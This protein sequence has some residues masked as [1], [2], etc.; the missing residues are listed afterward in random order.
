MEHQP[1]TEPG[2]GSSDHRNLEDMNIQELVSV[3]RTAFMA[4]DFD[5][6]EEVLVSRYNRIQ[7]EILHL[8]E[9]FELEKL[10]RFQAKEDLRKREELCE[11]YK[12]NYETLLKEVKKKSSLTE[13]DNVGELRKKKNALE[14]EVCELRKLKEK[15]KG[16]SNALA[17][18]RIKVGVLE[19]DKDA[20]F[21]VKNSELKKSMK[22]NSK[23][24]D[25]ENVGD[26]EI[27]ND[28]ME[29]TPL[30][31][32]EPPSKRSKTAQGASSPVISQMKLGASSSRHPPISCMCKSLFA[33][34]HKPL[35]EE[36]FPGGP[37]DMSVL[38][39]FE[40]HIAARI[41]RREEREL[42]RVVTHGNKLKKF[43]PIQLPQPILQA[44][45]TAGLT[46]LLGCSFIIIDNALVCAFVESGASF[47]PPEKMDTNTA[48]ACVM[49]LLG[50]SYAKAMSEMNHTKGSHLRLSW[51]REIYAAKCAEQEWEHASR[52][53][54]LHLVGCTILANKTHAFVDIKYLELFRDLNNCGNWSWGSAA[55][56]ILYK[57]LGDASIHYT[58]QIA[59]YI[60]LLQAW[61]YEYFPNIC[62]RIETDG[63]S[64]Q[65]C[66]A[67]RWRPVQ[68]TG[69]VQPYRRKLDDLTADDVIWTAFRD[70]RQYR[71]FE[72]I[73]MFSGYIR[74]G[75]IIVPYLPERVL[76]QF[77]VRQATYPSECTDKYFE[78]YRTISHPYVIPPVLKGNRPSAKSIENKTKLMS[79]VPS[80]GKQCWN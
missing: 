25:E 41:W 63:Y 34:R 7:T 60:T 40:D 35:S 38:T 44:V 14:L 80:V 65:L 61:I 77:G 22:K 67:C 2:F 26:S 48:R 29:P 52:A 47:S 59:G 16:D 8:Q 75:K 15:W 53:F 30:Q 27:G 51:L 49:A 74:W 72:D 57:Y 78:W 79:Q 28:T 76:R 55:L 1:K 17:E 42:L 36:P 11:R 37:Y 3:L 70:H 39:S 62:D 6:V 69:E 13:R 32:N 18:L 45:N 31:R 23:A 43:I 68:G 56:T 33:A 58:K 21:R 46:S 5:R 12:N 20:I 73:S 9:K 64:G 54:L 66:R 19:N 4:E 10:M 24:L 71:G 50:V